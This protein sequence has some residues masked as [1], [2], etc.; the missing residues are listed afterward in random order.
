MI[1]VIA[2]LL[3]KIIN[4]SREHKK[5]ELRIQITNYLK[6][7]INS[8][9]NFEKENFPEQ[10]QRLD[11]LLYII[12]DFDQ[13]NLG[14]RWLAIRYELNRTIILPLA[15]QAALS[16][17]WILQF[18]AA[19]AFEIYSEKG[20][21][22]YIDALITSNIPAIRLAAL[23]AAIIYGSKQALHDVIDQM[24]D[25]PL[26]TQAVFLQAFTNAPTITQPYIVDFLKQA[27][28]IETRV[29]CYRILIDYPA[30]KI[31]W[32]IQQDI[33]SSDLSLKLSSLRLFAYVEKEK[34]IPILIN[35]L[36]DQNWQTKVV[37]LNIFNYLNAETVI[38]QIAN[39][40]HDENWWV[41][42]SAA[43]TLKN[44]GQAGEDALT[45]T[46][47]K[48]DPKSLQVTRHVLRQL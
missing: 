9:D 12:N 34:A 36:M 46:H 2:S 3:A 24:R 39:C 42:L 29:T 44:S 48:F 45:A 16:S 35:L 11:I 17:S 37:V 30:C 32:D 43:Q 41:R 40:L 18:Y 31:D 5:Q 14:K 23:H 15:R 19:Q 22:I 1:V 33:D 38:P 10:W 7:L 20:D 47:V 21:E 6:H 13:Q 8:S 27:K 28:D 4:S 26:L 25:Q